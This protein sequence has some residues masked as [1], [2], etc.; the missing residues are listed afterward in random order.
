MPKT[1]TG[2]QETKLVVDL[3]NTEEPK[4]DELG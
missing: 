3:W 2:S 1:F 4:P